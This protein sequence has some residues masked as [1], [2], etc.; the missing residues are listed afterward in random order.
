MGKIHNQT[1]HRNRN[2]NDLY[3]NEKMLNLMHK[4]REMKI[5]LEIPC[6]P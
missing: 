4:R 5:M 2:T 3:T 6:L 1:V